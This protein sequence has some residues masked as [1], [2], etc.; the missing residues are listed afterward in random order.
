MA[1]TAIEILRG[2]RWQTKK[3]P[4]AGNVNLNNE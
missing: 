4:E 2:I 3:G 1:G